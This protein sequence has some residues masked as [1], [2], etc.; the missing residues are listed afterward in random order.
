MKAKTIPYSLIGG[1]ACFDAAVLDQLDK[2]RVAAVPVSV[3]GK[4][5]SPVAPVIPPVDT[6]LAE[7]QRRFM[8]RAELAMSNPHR[9]VDLEAA[10]KFSGLS[11]YTLER[12]IQEGTIGSVKER[13][14]KVQL[15][16]LQEYR[17]E[18]R[19]PTKKARR[20]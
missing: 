1:R 9:F 13:R 4:R 6:A 18:F 15:S 20:K 19:K 12:L 7:M 16:Q 3:S 14:T 2:P 11:R 8:E 10:E 5:V 17:G